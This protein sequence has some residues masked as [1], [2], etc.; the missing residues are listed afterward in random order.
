[1]QRQIRYGCFTKSW[2]SLKKQNLRLLPYNENNTL[3]SNMKM[4][5]INHLLTEPTHTGATLPTKVV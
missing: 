5:I 4:T 3:F 1:M 2:K